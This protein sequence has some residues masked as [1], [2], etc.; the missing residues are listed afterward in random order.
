[1]KSSTIILAISTILS[2]ILLTLGVSRII[3]NTK[4]HS[5]II[6]LITGI[7]LLILTHLYWLLIMRPR[8]NMLREERIIHALRKKIIQILNTPVSDIMITGLVTEKEETQALDVMNN[9]ATNNAGSVLVTDGK[10]LEGIITERDIISEIRRRSL[11][12]LSAKD[13]MTKNPRTITPQ[14]IIGQ[15][16]LIMVKNIVRKLPVAEKDN[17]SGIIT[18]TDILEIYAKFFN[19]HEFLTE[20]IPKV[21][22]YMKNEYIR[23]QTREPIM[24]ALREFIDNRSNAILVMDKTILKGIITER[25]ILKAYVEKKT[26]LKT[27]TAQDLMKTNVIT[28]DKD[29]SIIDAN[30]IMIKHNVRR[31]PVREGEEVIGII[32]QTDI[33]EA[34]SYFFALITSEDGKKTLT[35]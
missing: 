3:E 9:F 11:A 22:T 25:D 31:L 14:T 19:Q 4:D 17:L 8:V 13:I 12:K 23:A 30:T 2:V 21:Q 20:T 35:G 1:M 6:I 28:I 10:K 27:A 15:A 18:M 5:A 29:T 26:I 7:L 33:L 24:T 32:T 34:F 16:E